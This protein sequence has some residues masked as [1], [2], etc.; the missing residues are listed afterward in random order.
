MLRKKHDVA[1]NWRCGGRPTSPVLDHD[2]HR[3][4]R[5]IE[6]GEGDEQRV[7]PTIPRKFVLRSNSGSTLRRSDR[8]DLT[9]PGLAGHHLRLIRNPGTICRP[10]LVVR[11]LIHSLPNNLER[12]C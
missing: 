2:G 9:R 8:K 3:I 4:S 5:C 11:N 1:R 10:A 12:F 6:G 7:V